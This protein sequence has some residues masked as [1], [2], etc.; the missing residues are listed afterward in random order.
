MKKIFHYEFSG[1]SP[2]AELT[3][4]QVTKYLRWFQT[5][6]LSWSQKYFE[7]DIKMIEAVSQLST[8]TG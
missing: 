2:S 3:F 7:N 6:Q 4:R 1:A 8:S 5:L